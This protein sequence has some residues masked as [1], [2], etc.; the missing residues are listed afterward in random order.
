[1]RCAGPPS[2]AAWI[3]SASTRPM[4]PTTRSSQPSWRATRRRCAC[5]FC[6]RRRRCSRSICKNLAAAELV[7]RHGARG[8]GEAA[9]A[10][11]RLG[12]EHQ[13][14]RRR[15]L[16]GTP[17]LSY[18]SLSRQGGSAEPAGAAL[19]QQPVRTAVAPRAHSS[20]ADHG[21]RGTRASRGAALSTTR[22]A[23]CATWCRTICCSCCASW[24][25]NRRY[26]IT[27]MRCATRNSRCCAHC[28][29]CWVPLSTPTW[30][31]ASTAPER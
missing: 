24:R 16:P 20:R 27:R 5:S 8:A 13:S 15:D 18:R 9:G 19:R 26:R 14:E 30:C 28:G 29:R 1:M 25:W 7:T 6:R 4:R 17:D 2:A 10:G 22:P 31:A 12:R 23:H 11:S 21:G 3:T